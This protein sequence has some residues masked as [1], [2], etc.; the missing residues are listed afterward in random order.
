MF[1]FTKRMKAFQQQVANQDL[2]LT[3]ASAFIQ[4]IEKGNLASEIPQALQDS[5]IGRS[6][7]SIQLH[8]QKLDGE[9]KQ[10]NWLNEG[11]AMFSD[12]LR[13]KKS[14]DIQSLASEILRNLITYIQANQGG[15]FVLK[16]NE[17]G[18]S[19]LEL[20][21]CYAYDRKKI[22][23]RRIE[24]GDGLVGQCVL[25]K[26]IIY[27]KQIPRDYVS[28]TSGL[29][30]ATP[31]E[32]LIAPLL[33]NEEVFGVLELASFSEFP[34]YKIQ[35]IRRLTENIASSIRNAQE[36]DRILSLLNSSQQQ[37]EELRAQE[38]EMRQNMEELEATQ[39]EMQRKTEEITRASAEMRSIFH[40]INAT[41]ATIEFSPEGIV[42]TANDKFLS[43][44]KYNIEQIRGVHH[45]KF[46]PDDIVKSAE[47]ET[48]WS[49]L[50]AGESISGIFKRMSSEGKTIWLNAIY[51]PIFDAYG[52]VVKVIKFASD[53]TEQQEAVAQHKD[54]LSA[55]HAAM[56]VIE[57]TPAG[58]ILTANDNFLRSVKY[59]LEQITGKHH[60]MFVDA[61]V[62]NGDDYKKFW[63]DLAGGKSASGIFKRVDAAGNT[64]W[65]NAIYSPIRNA[66]GEV[67]KVIKFASDVTEQYEAPGKKL[68]GVDRVV[69][70]SL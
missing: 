9:E 44:V 43:S 31:R 23:T 47:Y 54:I 49:R 2:Q 24:V 28:I 56:A 68:N 13:N 36:S 18:E 51:N 20:V 30:E 15:L 50:A 53:I 69:A 52:Q 42:L 4:E 3:A 59:S 60:W 17:Q 63:E 6:L 29:G 39:E 48:F 40:G 19:F 22:I 21:S 35:F 11:L 61:T 7:S 8:L 65:L 58:T 5:N 34:E 16:K 46:V 14:L 55:I 45:R 64:V 10:R 66:N 70:K 57:F 25:E 67:A 1:F 32:V 27:L 38:E 12:I 62:A 26:D 33:L 37:A 41:M